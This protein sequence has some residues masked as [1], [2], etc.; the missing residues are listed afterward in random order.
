MTTPPS[1][2]V[3]TFS[4]RAD[5]TY[6]APNASG[7]YVYDSA[8]D[9]IE[10]VDGL[11]RERF[12]KTRLSRRSN[13]AP[14]L[15]LTA[16]QRYYG[17]FLSAGVKGTPGAPAIQSSEPVQAATPAAAARTY[18]R[19]EFLELG[20]EGAKAYEKGD[21]KRAQE[22]F[23]Q[24]VAA[25]PNSPEARAALGAVLVR[26]GQNDDALV[27]LDR[28]LQLNPEEVSAYVNRGEAYL[29]LGRKREA[30]ADLKKVIALDP[31]RKNPAANRARALLRG[32]L[33]R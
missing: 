27:H 21:L 3:I 23:E 24:L 17:C 6:E 20:R 31:A 29:K 32:E 12:S 7:H 16:N 9:T 18:T 19:G 2:V 8:H 11:H 22:I 15:S 33:L 28:A 25:D 13:G 1:T 26:R 4:L 10:W 14:A 5:G 30:E